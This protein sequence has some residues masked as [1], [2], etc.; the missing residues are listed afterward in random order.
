MIDTTLK[1]FNIT[2]PDKFIQALDEA[3]NTTKLNGF[4]SIGL[5]SYCTGNITDNGTYNTTY[6]SRP[7]GGFWFNPIDT[8][9]LDGTNTNDFLPGKLKKSLD[10]YRNASLWMAIIYLIAVI[11]TILEIMTCLV[12]VGGN[13][14]GSCF[15][16][17]LAGVSLL[18]TTAMAIASTAVFATL[19][20]TVSIVLKPYGIIRH[21]GR[22]MYAV[23]WLAVMLSFLTSALWLLDCCCCS[24][25]RTTARPITADQQQ[26]YRHSSAP[27]KGLTAPQDTSYPPPMVFTS[28]PSLQG[29]YQYPMHQIPPPSSPVGVYEPDKHVWAYTNSDC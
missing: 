18:F 17:L 21:M 15:A 4:F 22:H 28:P 3:N 29:S 16:W 13:R 20:T 25:Y 27:L 11:A 12:A 9:G 1:H 7:R 2:Q 5:S 8:W 23:T 14:L 24:R 10:M 26:S 6:C 19:A